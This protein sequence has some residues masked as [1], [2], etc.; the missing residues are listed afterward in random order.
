MDVLVQ[1]VQ[2]SLEVVVAEVAVLVEQLDLVVPE[3]EVLVVQ[4]RQRQLIQVVVAVV[5][6]VVTVV[7][8]VEKEL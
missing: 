4:V 7:A 8:M 3:L 6:E 1:H 2:F 5:Q